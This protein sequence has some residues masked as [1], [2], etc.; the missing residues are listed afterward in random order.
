MQYLLVKITSKTN[1]KAAL[2][3]LNLF[4]QDVET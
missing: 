1:H 4:I 3:M 2:R